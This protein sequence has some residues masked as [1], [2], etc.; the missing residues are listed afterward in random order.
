MAI[1]NGEE[2]KSI[3]L[4]GNV[5]CARM[6]A[7]AYFIYNGIFLAVGG[8]AHPLLQVVTHTMSAAELFSRHQFVLKSSSRSISRIEIIELWRIHTELHERAFD[9]NAEKELNEK[10]GKKW[11]QQQQQPTTIVNARM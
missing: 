11:K 10:W 9:E 6:C 8:A 7:A 2:Q 5:V 1:K 4:S 3:H